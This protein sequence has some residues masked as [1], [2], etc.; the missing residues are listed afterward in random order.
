MNKIT[1]DKESYK[2]SLKYEEIFL[3]PKLLLEL[4]ELIEL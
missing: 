4:F 3:E 1:L 2:L